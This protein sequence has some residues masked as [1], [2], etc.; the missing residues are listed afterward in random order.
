MYILMEV[1]LTDKET[2]SYYTNYK[3]E[4]ALMGEVETKL[5]QAMKSDIIKAELL[6]ACDHTGKI[7]DS[8]FYMVDRLN[9]DG[10][11][12][13][14][15]EEGEEDTYI[16]FTFANRLLWVTSNKQGETPNLQQYD[17]AKEA[18]ANYHLKRGTAM[19]DANTLAILTM[20]LE[21]GVTANEYWVRSIEIEPEPEEA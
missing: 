20:M 7:I 10:V 1:T 17:S 19:Q 11:I 8:K 18:E 13:P 14:M 3:N 12:Q 2:Q 5:G 4:T 16:P 6:I 15:P 21:N 9:K